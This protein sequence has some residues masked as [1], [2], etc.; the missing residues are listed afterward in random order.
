MPAVMSACKH[1]A[2]GLN[3]GTGC[4]SLHDGLQALHANACGQAHARECPWLSVEA[5]HDLPV[6]GCYR[7]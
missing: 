1:A 7:G 3:G 2:Q 5:L 6:L 4:E